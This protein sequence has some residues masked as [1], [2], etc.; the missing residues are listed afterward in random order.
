[1]RLHTTI[2][3]NALS[4]VLHKKIQR[5]LC[6]LTTTHRMNNLD[7][8][9]EKR[10]YIRTTASL[11]LL[12]LIFKLLGRTRTDLYVQSVTGLISFNVAHKTDF[13]CNGPSVYG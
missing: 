13:M 10:T 4:N 11:T 8:A 6:S 3:Y 12:A 2:P 1:M 9:F 5:C 7:M